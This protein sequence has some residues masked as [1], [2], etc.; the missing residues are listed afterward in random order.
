MASDVSLILLSAG[1]STRFG[2]KPKKQWSYVAN[3]PLW[4]YVAKKFQKIY[5]FDKIVITADKE[6]LD[7]M[8]S[9]ADDFD[10]VCG[11]DTRQNSIQNGIK[12]INTKFVMINDI[13][14]CCVPKKVVKSLLKH[15]SLATCVV[16]TLDISDTVVY[17]NS[18][19]DREKT[20]LVQTPQ[21]SVTQSLIQAI[22][23]GIQ[24]TDESSAIKANGGKVMFVKGSK[25]SDKI[26]YKK[27]IK[28]QS[29]LKKPDKTALVGF[30]YDIHQFT[31]NKPMVLC[32]VKIDSKF[33]LLAH[34]DGDVAIHSV[35]D[36]I[37]GAIGAGDIGDF[38]PD[39]SQ[40]YKNTNSAK[41]LQHI[42]SF[43]TKTGFKIV[44]IDMTIVAQVP[45][46]SPYKKLMRFSMAKILGI[47]PNYINIKATTNEHIDGIGQNKAM[48]V[49]S[50]ANLKYRKVC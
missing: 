25:K 29:C 20:F 2:Q 27:D 11:S 26:T 38:F 23:K 12:N 14:R 22:S 28:N 1:N 13:A 15:K 41:L 50:V 42:V 46:I 40:Q 31:Q 43:A 32:G 36:A 17:Q 47:K 8:C 49:Y 4:L 16:P 7:Y 44:H 18:Y 3:T 19:I 5:K 48:A 39:S 10:I 35:I 45:K 34:S 21:I 37:L 30:G 9:F 33:G 6:E 24:Y